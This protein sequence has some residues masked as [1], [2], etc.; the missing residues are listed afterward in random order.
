MEDSPTT[1]WD[2]RLPWHP[3]VSSAVH[4]ML[5]SNH[6]NTIIGEALHKLCGGDDA[7]LWECSCFIAKEGSAP[8]I[9]H[10]DTIFTPNAEVYTIFVALQN[11]AR[12]QGLT[13]LIPGTHH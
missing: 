7:I 8:Q 4:E 12:H 13:R 10:S 3:T 1:R 5:S 2:I 6:N 9:V 11:I